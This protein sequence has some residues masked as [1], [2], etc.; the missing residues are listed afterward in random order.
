MILSVVIANQESNAINPCGL[1]AWFATLANRK[2][3]AARYKAFLHSDPKKA[4]AVLVLVMALSL[5][6]FLFGCTSQSEPFSLSSTSP[7]TKLQVVA[8]FYPLYE[9]AKEVGGNKTDVFVLI[10]PGA[11]PH[12]FE[13]T[14]GDIRKNAA[15]DVFIYNGAGFE[16]WVQ[17]I[18]DGAGS[19]SLIVVD[20]SKTILSSNDQ[21]SSS[22]NPDPHFWLD[23]ILAKKQ[24][25]AI[26]EAFSQKD[27]GSRDYY[28]ANAAAYKS[29]LDS[30]DSRIRTSLFLSNCTKKD[31]LIT[32]A[33][34]EYFCSR[35]G[36]NQIAIS[37]INPEAEPTPADLANIINQAKAKNITSVFF[38]RLLNPRAANTIASELGG[39]ALVF[40]S[41][42][43]LSEGEQ[44]RGQNY[45][46]LMDEN[47]ISMEKAL[48]CK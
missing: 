21:T 34:L 8:S 27:P 35:Y 39:Q 41:I 10:P 20:T 13:P 5:P 46:T 3:I 14:P 40:N 29:K 16:P 26:A 44:L 17:K 23:P 11:E 38:E 25:D 33:T 6:L 15:A 42:H 32:H 9:F 43:G 30:L 31:I 19:S 47:R 45:I 12:D 36:C 18:I 37:G 7:N 4:L 24:V 28:I 2:T 1:V 22:V 48:G